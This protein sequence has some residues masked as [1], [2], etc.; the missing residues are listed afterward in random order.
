MAKPTISTRSAFL[1]AAALLCLYYDFSIYQSGGA[2]LADTARRS[3]RKHRDERGSGGIEELPSTV[4]RPESVHRAVV[5]GIIGDSVSV[6]IISVGSLTRTEYLLAQQRTFGSHQAVRHFF[7]ITERNDTDPTC[8]A[9]LTPEKIEGV[10]EFCSRAAADDESVISETL[11]TKL[12]RPRRHAGWLCAQTR[13]ISG[14]HGVLQKYANDEASLPDYLFIIDDDTW[15]NMDLVVDVLRRQYPPQEP[16]ALA[17][18]NFNFLGKPTEFKYPYGGFGSYLTAA[19]VQRLMRPIDC[20]STSSATTPGEEDRTPTWWTRYACWRLEKNLIGE[21][22]FFENGMSVAELMRAYAAGLPFTSVDAWNETGYCLHSDHAL[23]YFVNFYHA[24]V[25]ESAVPDGEERREPRDKWRRRHGYR[26]LVRN[27]REC[28][29][30]RDKCPFNAR[31]CHY[32]TPE[33]MDQ[34]HR[35]QQHW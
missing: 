30:L 16:Y 18:C 12:F 8:H 3:R 4:E 29:H 11:R 10:V 35:L 19:A 21:R 34:L 7:R 25:P 6:D 5:P 15:L 17:G 26:D 28:R 33:R 27:Q 24:T 2:Y 9:D 13:P 31:I 22:Q 14:L 1:V 32:M 20:S 23:A